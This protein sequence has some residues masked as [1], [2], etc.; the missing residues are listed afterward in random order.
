MRSDLDPVFFLDDRVR[1]ILKAGSG[2]CVFLDGRIRIQVTPPGSAT[3]IISAHEFSL[4]LNRMI[5]IRTY[6]ITVTNCSLTVFDDINKIIFY[7]EKYG[8]LIRIHALAKTGCRLDQNIGMY[9]YALAISQQ[10]TRTRLLG[11]EILQ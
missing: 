10:G 11:A 5:R 2:S 9:N 8:H 1:N 6:G 3:F 4:E 7:W